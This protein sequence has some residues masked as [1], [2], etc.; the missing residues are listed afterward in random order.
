[1][2]SPPPHPAGVLGIYTIGIVLFSF[3]FIREFFSLLS[4]CSCCLKY[5]VETQ[6]TDRVRTARLLHKTVHQF[7]IPHG[8]VR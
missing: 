1:M 2:P 3:Q 5:R 4:H 7:R 8:A 6:L